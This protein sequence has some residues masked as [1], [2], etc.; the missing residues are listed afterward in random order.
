MLIPDDFLR[1]LVIYRDG[2]DGSLWQDNRG[3]DI[4]PKLLAGEVD[5]SELFIR[6]SDLVR[7]AK[8]IEFE[9]SE[10]LK[11]EF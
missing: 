6:V 5:G 8:F 9:L 10:S 11:H 4:W 2:S 1:R 3:P 7:L